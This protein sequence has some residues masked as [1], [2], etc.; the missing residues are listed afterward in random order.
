MPRQLYRIVQR[1]S[2]YTGLFPVVKRNKKGEE[3]GGLFKESGL[4]VYLDAKQNLD[5]I[6]FRISYISIEQH[7]FHQARAAALRAYEISGPGVQ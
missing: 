7:D 5:I 3:Q 1:C 6:E 4:A 2:H